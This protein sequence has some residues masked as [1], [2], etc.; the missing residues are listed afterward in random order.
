MKAVMDCLGMWNHFSLPVMIFSPITC[1]K[2][3]TVLSNPAKN[4]CIRVKL[5][6]VVDAGECL[7]KTTYK[8]KGDGPLAVYA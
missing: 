8:L 7:V 5:A 4:A 6:V 3:L 1:Q 2:L